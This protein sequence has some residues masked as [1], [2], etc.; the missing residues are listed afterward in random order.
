MVLHN[1][2]TVQYST[3]QYSAVPDST[4]EGEALWAHLCMAWL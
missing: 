4:D 1:V 3:V 2:S